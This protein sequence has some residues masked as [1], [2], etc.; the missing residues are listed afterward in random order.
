[1]SGWAPPPSAKMPDLTQAVVISHFAHMKVVPAQNMQVVA[2]NI[3][4]F[5]S[6]RREHGKSNAES[7]MGD[8]FELFIL[9][10]NE[11]KVTEEADTRKSFS[12][13]R[14]HLSSLCCC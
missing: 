5:T 13:F 6:R 10:A 9:D 1:M 7:N 12:S 4:D 8:R 11:K 14:L 2:N 3:A